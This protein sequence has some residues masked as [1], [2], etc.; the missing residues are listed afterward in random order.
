MN[1]NFRLVL[2]EWEDSSQPLPSW[3]HLDSL[4]DQK[5]VD[6]VSVGWLIAD[7]QD[8]KMIAPNFGDVNSSDNKQASGII[9]IPVRSIK[10]ISPLIVGD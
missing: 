3:H 7:N 1:D 6:C 4:P 5:I 8:V 2:V 10:R 9:N